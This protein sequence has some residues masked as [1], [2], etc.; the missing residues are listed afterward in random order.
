[1]TWTLVIRNR[2]NILVNYESIL[3]MPLHKYLFLLRQTLLASS[4]EPYLVLQPMEV[5]N[6]GFCGRVSCSPG[7]LQSHYVAEDDP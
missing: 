1:M 2:F 3:T 7:C 4:T 5:F 6:F